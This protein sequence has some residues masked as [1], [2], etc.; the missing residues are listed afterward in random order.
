MG[1]AGAG[2]VVLA[3]RVVEV[4]H[5]RGDGAAPQWSSGSGFV[6]RGA[7]V[8]TAAHAV[9]VTGELLVRFRGVEERAARVCTLPGGRPALDT[10]F[11]L[12]VLEIVDP[13][14]D[15]TAV[16]VARLRADPTLDTPNLDGCVA[17]GFPAF[18]VRTRVG[19]DR[20]VRE[21]VRVDGYIP[22]GQGAV[23]G[24][25]TL[26]VRDA[27]QHPAIPVGDV[28]R[29]PWRGISGAVV[30][31]G[32]VAVGVVSEHHPPA[33]VNGL[34][35]VPLAVLDRSPDS[36]GWWALLGVSDP[37]RV[38]CLPEEREPVAPDDELEHRYR[39][40][41][42]RSPDFTRLP[43][44]F[45]G[46][47]ADFY[48][49]RLLRAAGSAGGG[50][51]PA[52]PVT[53][54]V[55]SVHRLVI[56]APAGMGKTELLHDLVR[57]MAGADLGGVP[58]FV[59]LHDLARRG[60]GRDLLTFAVSES[61]GDLIDGSEVERIVGALR[62]RRERSATDVVF[63]FDGLDEVPVARQGDVL[64]RVRKVD[65][66]VLTSRPSGRIDVLQDGSAYWIDDLNDEAVVRFVSRWEKRSP[67][68]RRLLDGLAD[69]ARLGELARFPQL[70]LLLCWLWRPGSAGAG[71]TRI[72]IIA[73]AVDEAFA[74]A[75]RLTELP[76]GY[77][78]V[79][80]LR[81][82]RALQ[83]AA[84]EALSTGEGNRLTFTLPHMLT[85]MEEAGGPDLAGLLLRFARR[86][87][88]L[89]AAAA[90][91][92]VQFLHHVF[93]AHLAGEA[94]V[95]EADPV[96]A[97]DRLIL[98][99]D[100][101]D[102][103]AV[104]AALDPQRM[105]TLI[106]DRLAAS[107]ADIFRMRWRSAAVC[108]AGLP[109]LRSLEE[110]LRQV[111]DEVLAGASE[112]W[113]R[114]RFAPVIGYLRTGYMRARLRESLSDEDAYL[115]WAA[116]EGLRY[117][118]E[119]EAVPVLVQ[120]LADEPWSA[121]Q[122][123]IVRALGR[124]R[125]PVAV[126]PLWSHYE[127]RRSAS[128]YTDFSAVGES[129]ARL[130]A[131]PELHRIIGRVAGEESAIEALMGARPFVPPPLGE[132]IA[133]ALA[134]HVILTEP[135]DL[136]RYLAVADDPAATTDQQLEAISGLGAVG[137]G[138][139][140][141]ALLRMMVGTTS[142]E[143]ADRAA[144]ALLELEGSPDFGDVV[145]LVYDTV[146]S[147]EDAQR[148]D[149]ALA[150]LLLWTSSA[151]DAL[152]GLNFP[153]PDAVDDELASQ[154]DPLVR[155]TAVILACLAGRS[156]WEQ[157]R[158]LARDG[159]ALVRE[160]A[161]AALGRAPMADA[162][163]LIA[164]TALRDPEPRVRRAGLRAL[165]MLAP[166]GAAG[167]LS[168]AL[169]A[170]DPDE[171][172]E[173]AAAIEA[174]GDPAALPL[175][176]GRLGHEAV[177]RVRRAL[178]AAA[179]RAAR[180]G[181]L[182]PDVAA[183]IMAELAGDADAREFGANAAGEGGLTAADVRLRELMYSDPSESVRS[184]AAQA[185][186]HVATPEALLGLVD[187]LAAGEPT[188]EQLAALAT[189]LA[190]P[191]RDAVDRLVGRIAEIGG[192]TIVT[193]RAV[194][195]SYSTH[196]Y[197]IVSGGE[198]REVAT[199]VEA[200]SRPDPGE[201]WNAVDELA[202]QWTESGVLGRIALAM[203]DPNECVADRAAAVVGDISSDFAPEVLDAESRELL[204][205]PGNLDGL[206]ELLETPGAAVRVGWLLGH[207][208]FLP[209]LLRAA[210]SGRSAVRQVLWDLGDRHG[211][212]LLADGGAV[213][214]TGRQVRW[215]ELPSVLR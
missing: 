176:S 37:A 69:D 53:E 162:A 97:V 107:G 101:E 74:R 89:T 13:P 193:D 18:Q 52:L 104:A 25:A 109:D 175:I 3:Q 60:E 20:P 24:L 64:A 121:V 85:L 157:L 61:F 163:D 161:V 79:V 147:P 214:A 34:T 41:L 137:T 2:D 155:T 57:R 178:I 130:G 136:D 88:L 70:L 199:L 117:L 151:Q 76:D 39:E 1:E 160:A 67:G 72:G 198:P 86:S 213:L 205:R 142:D 83:R 211:L 110:Q 212:R 128:T 54:L 113:S 194:V 134:P 143:V 59:R 8:L 38:P 65:R 209:D 49:P 14:G 63:L 197:I 201:R 170:D 16:P 120:R 35:V 17:F 51:E 32:G 75:V 171:R 122:T 106:L 42:L 158:E 153:E 55:E 132:E 98:R 19:R 9:G 12:A 174:I 27:P 140:A 189:A 28:A 99:L 87:G 206:L 116:V 73:T 91:D 184:A 204:G 95:A 44:P 190:H 169:D 78:E 103:L 144:A 173:A 47:P 185:Y 84:L 172:A 154:A 207:V 183:A 33:G 48:M 102:V 188:D 71:S 94:L 152:V 23:E 145:Q 210:V 36:A 165:G 182:P 123:A 112:W 138:E 100:G 166:P 181:P 81:A 66:F 177:L 40:L 26:R 90:G 92:D 131:A 148:Y 202:G 58:V 180:P 135:E 129:L 105:P 46:L 159:E 200:L 15:A 146:R 77:E 31:A 4:L 93:R 164:D 150:F 141:A 7:L 115:R 45:E 68:A 119:P 124:L 62:R 29:S 186:G 196:T 5:D 215:E 108:M 139:A 126:G 43:T 30:F 195:V 187:E 80:P 21:S 127:R 96:P 118:G 6:V 203:L 149:G 168:T 82:R 192:R 11:D 56:V 10:E 133:R 125:D 114:H 179:I 167:V 156:P 191:A 111:A 22:M 208:E 50:H